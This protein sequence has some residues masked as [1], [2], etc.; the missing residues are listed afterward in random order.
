MSVTDQPADAILLDGD[1]FHFLVCGVALQDFVDPILDE[2]GHA[3]LDR[4]LQH[5]FG[6]RLL[7]HHT[8]HAVR[9]EEQFV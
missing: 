6:A 4:G 9:T 3:I 7:L 1:G 8:F 2:R 5:V